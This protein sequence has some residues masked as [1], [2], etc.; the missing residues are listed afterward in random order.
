MTRLLTAL[1]L[2][3]LL[4]GVLALPWQVFAGAVALLSMAGWR[5]LAGLARSIGAGVRP[6]TAVLSGLTTFGVALAA[7]TE[8]F[9]FLVAVMLFAGIWTVARERHDPGHAVRALATT[10]GGLLWLSV[11]LGLQVDI[12]SGAHGVA[13]LLLLYASVA[14]GD[15]AA[16]YGGTALGRHR[17]APQLSPKKSIEGSLFGLAGA[18]AGA[19]VVSTWLPTIGYGHAAL[20][21][22]LL[23]A[24]GQVGDLLESSVKRAADT[25]DSSDL[26]PGHG[27]ILDR[28]DAHLLAGVALWLILNLSPLAS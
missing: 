28:I 6:E 18:A 12:R 25:K 17:L 8:R 3:A 2:I 15:S 24:I 16:Y 1:V 26:L 5:E 4:A 10:V 14:I 7:P 27:G 11:P 9:G 21:G 13:W 23:G 19:A 20:M 22:A